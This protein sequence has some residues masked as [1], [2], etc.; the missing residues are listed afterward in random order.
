MKIWIID[1]YSSE[2]KYG[3]ISRQYDFLKEFSKRGHEVLVIS[4]SFSH[5]THSFISNKSCFCS[6][7]DER[8]HYAYVRTTPYKK[9]NGIKRIINTIS[10]VI[11]VR[12]HYKELV[13]MYGSPD[14]VV[15][16]SV[17]PFT[18]IIAMA[19]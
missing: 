10:F 16:S 7:V 5:Y 6:D 9:N 8:A 12:I 14:I 17:H 18:W 13:N 4:S 19:S 3:G 15:G 2:P 1:H 11:K